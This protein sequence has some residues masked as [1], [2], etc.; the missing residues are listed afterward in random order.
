M[1]LLDCLAGMAVE[2]LN[3]DVDQRPEMTVVAERL[4]VLKR[5]RN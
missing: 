2:C 4:L 3:L 1:E 5:S